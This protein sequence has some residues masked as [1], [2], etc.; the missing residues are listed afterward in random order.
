MNVFIGVI[1]VLLIIGGFVVLGLYKSCRI[2]I[3]AFAPMWIAGVALFIL[4]L[5][6]TIIPT[7]YT[8]VRVVFG[9]VNETPAKNGLCWKIPFAEEIKKVNNKQQDI[10]F[11][12]EIWGETSERTA[13]SFSGIIVTY[14]ISGDRSAW[15]YSHVS[16]YQDNLVSTAL[17][18]SAIKT[19]SKTLTDVEATNRGKIEPLALETIQASLDGKYG[20]GVVTINKV[21]INNADFEDSYNAAI[22][23]K[24]QAQLEYEQQQIINQKNVEQAKAEAEAAIAKANGEAEALKIAAQAEA[25]ANKT[26]ADSLSEDIFTNYMLDKWNG[27]LPLVVGDGQTI[28]DLGS[29]LDKEQ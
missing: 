11:S 25:E 6:F 14:S 3:K 5:S 2:G 10:E 27:E 22:A 24:Q 4:S 8:G 19:A 21:V 9:Q 20:Q 18:S 26:I 15:I 23:S 16:N 28:F 13:I 17:V 29:Y 1:G 7:G 12:G